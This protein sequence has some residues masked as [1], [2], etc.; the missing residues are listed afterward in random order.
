MD[1]LKDVYQAS[2]VA[3]DLIAETP[4]QQVLGQDGLE[5]RA[6][7][8]PD[9]ISELGKVVHLVRTVRNNL[10]HGGKHQSDGW[11]DPARTRRLL[12][13]VVV[14]L[15]ELAVQAEIERLP[16]YLLTVRP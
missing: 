8:F 7:Q 15:G 10:F 1:A 13:L 9:G 5:F 2:P 16:P 4:K 3:L 14:V 11:D 6:V 12:H